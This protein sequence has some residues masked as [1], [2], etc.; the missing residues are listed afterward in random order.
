MLLGMNAFRAFKKVS[1][2]F[3]TSQFAVIAP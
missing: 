1:L 2:D 3:G